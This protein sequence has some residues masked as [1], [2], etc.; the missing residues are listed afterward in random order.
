MNNQ[1]CSL[2]ISVFQSS[3]TPS[4][5]FSGFNKKIFWQLFFIFLILTWGKGNLYLKIGSG[6]KT[7]Q[8]QHL[9]MQPLNNWNV[10]FHKILN[11]NCVWSQYSPPCRVW[12]PQISAQM[13][14]SLGYENEEQFH[15]KWEQDFIPKHNGPRAAYP[16]WRDK[17][18]LSGEIQRRRDIP[19]KNELETV[20]GSSLPVVS[21]LTL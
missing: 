5:H 2:R 9:L 17:L 20:S 16:S 19:W 18:P 1:T 7:L 11:E 12:N 13:L 21:F 3:L 6:L 8:N 14:Q 15:L 4:P 10:S